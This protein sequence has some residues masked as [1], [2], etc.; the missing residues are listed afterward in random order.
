MT[1]N[2]VPPYPTPIFG[3]SP[4]PSSILGPLPFTRFPRVWGRLNAM[5]QFQLK[6]EE[7]GGSYRAGFWSHL[8]CWFF[9]VALFIKNIE[10]HKAA[11]LTALCGKGPC[12]GKALVSPR[13]FEA[14]FGG[15][16][17]H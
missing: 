1:K 10:P 17:A 3:N 12:N 6:P 15:S 2:C 7:V 9:S 5:E 4:L 11:N 8:F 16:G 13:N 14:M